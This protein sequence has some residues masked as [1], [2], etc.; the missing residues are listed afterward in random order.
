MNIIGISGSLRAGS[1]NHGLLEAFKN[2]LPEDVE[3][4]IV[5]IGALPHF[6][7]DLESDFPPEAQA[8]KDTVADADAVIIATPEYNRSIPGV[9]KNAIDWLSR[10]YG[11]NSFA[12]KPVLVVGAS[13][14]GIG[15]ALAQYHLKQVLLHLDAHVMGQPEFF[16]GGAA[17]KFDANGTLTDEDTKQRIS[18]AIRT[19]LSAAAH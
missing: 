17:E 18:A 3:M 16:V 4:E 11:E 8:L 7:A 5:S 13:P 10:P 19:L 2:A 12:G 15:T 14:G 1:Y 9:L 6:N